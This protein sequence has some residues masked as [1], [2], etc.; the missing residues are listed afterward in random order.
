KQ[1]TRQ[2]ISGYQNQWQL[3]NGRWTIVQVPATYTATLTSGPAS[4][5]G[6]GADFN[7]K[8]NGSGGFLIRD[9]DELC[10]PGHYCMV[11]RRI[12]YPGGHNGVQLAGL[13][14]LGED[15]TF[16]NHQYYWIEVGLSMAEGT[17][18][19]TTM[20]SD[21]NAV[22]RDPSCRVLN[23]KRSMFRVGGCF[24]GSTQVRMADGTDKKVSDVQADDWVL[25]P[26]YNAP[27][28]VKKV[29]KGPEKKA[30]WEV[31]YGENRVVVTEDHPFLTQQGW[32]QTQGLKSGEV[33][34]GD[35]KSEKITSVK[36]LKYQA[37]ED[38]WNF[39]L[40]TEDPLAH[41]VVANGIPTGDL[42]TQ[43]ELKKGKRILP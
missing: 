3:I 26:I 14:S 20:A 22:K 40:D 41:V 24:A 2:N 16:D 13:N 33:L 31:R 23:T 10:S 9:S 30:L 1:Y 42:V 34:I 36:K 21:P 29:V 27:V 35:G 4:L 25:N 17:N 43:Q 32:V 28:K 18:Y 19:N 39:E 7:Y 37:P 38:V 11:V 12:N 8:Y 6:F 15:N 5:V